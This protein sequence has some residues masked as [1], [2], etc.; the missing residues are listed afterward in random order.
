MKSES[1]TRG[2]AVVTPALFF[3]TAALSVT[4]H[5]GPTQRSNC[6]APLP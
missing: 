5:P 1:T 2:A 6:K 3:S 4:A